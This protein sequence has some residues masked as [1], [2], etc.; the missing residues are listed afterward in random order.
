M[1][2][3]KGESELSGALQALVGC[4]SPSPDLI[5][6]A[7][8]TALKFQSE[9][10]MVVFEV[11][12][13]VKRAVAS[14]KLSGILVMDSICKSAHSKEKDVLCARFGSRMKQIFLSLQ[15]IP[16]GDKVICLMNDLS[17]IRLSH[18]HPPIYLTF[19]IAD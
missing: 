14:D 6:K 8:Q 11:E 9:Y 13:F 18:P 2:T 3:W 4:Q 15:D 19:T 16:P 5:K 10:K 1:S 17:L 12:K 7:S